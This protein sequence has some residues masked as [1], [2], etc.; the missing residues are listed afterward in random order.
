VPWPTLL[1]QN[2]MNKTPGYNQEPGYNN[3]PDAV[4]EQPWDMII[5]AFTPTPSPHLVPACSS[6]ARAGLN[7]WGYSDPA[8]DILF[9][10]LM[11]KEALDTN[12]RKQ[13]YADISR[14]IADDQPV[15]SSP[16]RA[17]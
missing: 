4:S 2:V 15:F 3:G 1:R 5:M 8:V 9:D 14:T 12:A 7:Y 17:E 6:P 16:S 10:K 11:S 13:M